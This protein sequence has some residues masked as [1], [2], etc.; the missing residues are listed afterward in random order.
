MTGAIISG[1]GKCLKCGH[2]ILTNSSAEELTADTK[3]TCRACG[4]VTTVREAWAT[5]SLK[6]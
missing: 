5:P 6:P 4:H 1:S 2:N 3:V